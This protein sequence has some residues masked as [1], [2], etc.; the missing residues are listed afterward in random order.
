MKP[1]LAT[2]AS[3][4]ALGPVGCLLMR[5]LDAEILPSWLDDIAER[6]VAIGPYT[7]NL[8]WPEV[9]AMLSYIA[10]TW[11]FSRQ[12]RRHAASKWYWPLWALLFLSGLA[13]VNF[14][15]LV[16]GFLAIVGL[17][18]LARTYDCRKALVSA[19]VCTEAAPEERG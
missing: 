1:A 4:L 5:M 16:A 17:A 9:T 15:N 11:I 18:L 13:L 14:G 12:S 2:L 19:R 3:V 8:A 7:A 10:A 6:P